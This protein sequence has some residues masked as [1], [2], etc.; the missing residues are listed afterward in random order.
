MCRIYFTDYAKKLYS[1]IANA[2]SFVHNILFFLLYLVT[3]SD[4]PKFLQK[5]LNSPLV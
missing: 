2:Y 1:N 4:T 5:L 3:I